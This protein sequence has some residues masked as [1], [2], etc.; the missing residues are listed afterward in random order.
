MPSAHVNEN[1]IV[2]FN[3][4]DRTINKIEL[5]SPDWCTYVVLSSCDQNERVWEKCQLFI[6]ENRQSKGDEMSLAKEAL[7]EELPWSQKL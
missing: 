3:S 5:W 4:E 2:F 6:D 1:T 7:E